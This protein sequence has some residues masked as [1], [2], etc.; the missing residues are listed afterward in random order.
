[1]VLARLFEEQRSPADEF[2]FQTLIS[3]ELLRYE[4]MNRVHARSPTRNRIVDATELVE[5]I[6]LIELSA[7]ALARALERFPVPVRTLD[8]LHLASMQYLRARG[9]AVVLATYDRRLGDAAQALGF[10]LAQV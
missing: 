9:K 1:V 3:S 4:V 6:E 10:A 8:G 7:D 2:W 5:S